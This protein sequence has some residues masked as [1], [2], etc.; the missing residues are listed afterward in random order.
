M[1][2]YDTLK[3]GG[4]ITEVEG[5]KATDAMARMNPRQSKEAF[6]EG[7][8]EF[9]GIVRTAKERSAGKLPQEIA[10]ASTPA[11]RPTKTVSGFTWEKGDDG[12]WYRKR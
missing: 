5:K 12:K 1:Q 10:P 4:Q 7:I 6:L 8:S 9:Q 3:G 2:A 11:Q